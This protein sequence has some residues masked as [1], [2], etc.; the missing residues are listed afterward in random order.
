MNLA[1]G[2]KNK[3]S[4]FNYIL[5]PGDV[6]TIPKSNNIVSITGAIGYKIINSDKPNIN[7]PFH[8][9][10]R[11]SYYIKK[12]GGGYNSNA[13]RREVYTISSSGHVKNSKFFGVLK[14]YIRKGDKIIV[15]FKQPKK[16]KEKSNP[17]NWNSI[18]ENTTTKL[19]G[20][21]TLLILANTAFSN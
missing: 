6:L 17:I 20:I 5:K 16:K 15:E 13:K 9:S 1:D 18:I 19:T 11:A 14:P 4:K 7:T 3:N 10:R 21:L 8:S 12:Y 2:L